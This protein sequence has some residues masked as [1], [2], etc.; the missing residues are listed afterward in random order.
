MKNGKKHLIW[1][2]LTGIL[3]IVFGVSRL[4]NTVLRFVHTIYK[5]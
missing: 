4:R 3:T 5:T 2:L 1:I